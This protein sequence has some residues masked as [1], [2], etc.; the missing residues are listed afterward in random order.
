[1][2]FLE[3]VLGGEK[4]AITIKAWIVGNFMRRV[5]AII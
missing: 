1:M 2:V 4:E 5:G 3:C